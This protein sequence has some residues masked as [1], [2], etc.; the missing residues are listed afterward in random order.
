MND[1]STPRLRLSHPMI[2]MAA[3]LLLRLIWAALVPADPISDGALYDAF[4]R[5]IAS[6]HGYA[7][8]D[9]TMTE[10]WPVGTSAVYSVLYR[11]FG[12]APWVIPAFQALLGA[13]IV[14]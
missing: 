7:F 4:A 10:Y 1:L 6:G 12:V 2:I 9:G 14:G 11:V 8:P 3:A 13:V 5:S